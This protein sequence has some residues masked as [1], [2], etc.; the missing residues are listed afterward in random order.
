[1]AYGF[2]GS[3]HDYSHVVFPGETEGLAQC[4]VCHDDDT[5]Y[6]VDASVLATTID[7]GDDLA[8]PTDDINVTANTAACSSCH[9]SDLAR[10]HMQQ[11]GGA[12]DAV[13]MSDGTLISA[14]AGTVIETCALCH[15]PGRSA[16]VSGVH[17][18]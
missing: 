14:S 11:N 12:Y 9:E 16:D 10:A 17:G 7:S 2:G 8:D 3:L 6:P 13:Q 15:G 18:F 4:T 5:Y 1:F